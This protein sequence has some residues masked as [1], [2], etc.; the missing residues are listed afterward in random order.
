MNLKFLD[1]IKTNYK[2]NIFS[3]EELQTNKKNI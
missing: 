2:N 1:K 3:Q